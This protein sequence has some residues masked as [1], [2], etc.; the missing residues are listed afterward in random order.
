MKGLAIMKKNSILS[1]LMCI[2]AVLF[3]SGCNSGLDDVSHKERLSIKQRG[4]EIKTYQDLLQAF[5]DGDKFL[6]E[7]HVDKTD[8]AEQQKEKDQGIKGVANQLYVHRFDS[9]VLTDNGGIQFSGS[10]D[11]TIHHVTYL[12]TYKYTFLPSGKVDVDGD[13]IIISIP[14]HSG[15][16]QSSQNEYDLVGELGDSVVVYA[17]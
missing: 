12:H 14:H 6:V 17:Y 9:G 7:F 5:K 10:V 1:M 4:D 16:Q 11:W 3:L 8:A 13:N 15:V 2:S